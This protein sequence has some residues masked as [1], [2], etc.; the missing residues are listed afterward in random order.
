MEDEAKAKGKQEYCDRYDK[1]G[2]KMDKVEC[3]RLC[4][5]D[6]N[7]IKEDITA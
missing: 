1:D 4:Y 5:D 6:T 3:A 2:K 7:K